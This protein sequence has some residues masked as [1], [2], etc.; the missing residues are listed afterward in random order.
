[1]KRNI[2]ILNDIVAPVLSFI[3]APIAFIYRLV[4]MFIKDVIKTIYGKVVFL[5]SMTIIGWIL[6]NFITTR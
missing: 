1:M 6:T 2:D 5:V 3:W 4:S